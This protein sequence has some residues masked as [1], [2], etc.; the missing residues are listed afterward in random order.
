MRDLKDALFL[1]NFANMTASVT[2]KEYFS[3]FPVGAAIK[4]FIAWANLN[5]AV[6]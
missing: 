3:K 2:A 5:R 1:L 6:Q 4:N